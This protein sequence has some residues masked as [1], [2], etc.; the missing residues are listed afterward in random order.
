M[1]VNISPGLVADEKPLD[2]MAFTKM[3]A[4]VRSSVLQ[5][6]SSNISPTVRRKISEKNSSALVGGVF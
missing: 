1:K 6:L 5:P 4:E 3:M 2:H